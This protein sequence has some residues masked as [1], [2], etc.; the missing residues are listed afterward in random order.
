MRVATTI[1]LGAAVDRLAVLGVKSKSMSAE[2]AALMSGELAE[3][4]HAVGAVLA[5]AKGSSVEHIAS[6][7]T[8]V[9]TELFHWENAAAKLAAQKECAANIRALYSVYMRIRK[10]NSQRHSIVAR[11]DG[12]EAEPKVYR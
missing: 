1:S 6:E 8:D 3:L 4:S 11:I 5:K 12:A 10:L 7:L 9:H 2:H